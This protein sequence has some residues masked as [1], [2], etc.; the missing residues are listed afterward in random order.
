[1]FVIILMFSIDQQCNIVQPAW[2]FRP[3]PIDPDE[4]VLVIIA[5]HN[6]KKGQSEADRI[7]FFRNKLRSKASSDVGR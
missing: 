3:I 6:G 5:E 7:I 1:M 2:F 4:N